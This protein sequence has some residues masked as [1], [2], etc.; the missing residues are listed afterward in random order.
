MTSA[1]RN[2]AAAD[3]TGP[4]NSARYTRMPFPIK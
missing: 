1:G 2:C 4:E 3:H